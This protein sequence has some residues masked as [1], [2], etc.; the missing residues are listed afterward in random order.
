MKL[1]GIGIAVSSA[2]GF[3]SYTAG[4]LQLLFIVMCGISLI[5]F[6]I[7]G[8]MTYAFLG[9]EAM[10]ANFQSEIAVHRKTRTDW[11]KDLFLAGLPSFGAAVISTAVLF[12]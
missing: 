5:C 9:G 3:I 1:T 11:A 10:H 12:S 4:D 6:G 7:S 8:F 2:A